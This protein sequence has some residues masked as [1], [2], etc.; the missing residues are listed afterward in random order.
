MLGNEIGLLMVS[1]DGGQ[2]FKPVN[3]RVQ[4]AA[5]LL[6]IGPQQLLVVGPQGAE[7]VDL[8]AQDIQ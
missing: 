3:K 8:T 6:A 5:D 1:R 4:P 7:R 2:S